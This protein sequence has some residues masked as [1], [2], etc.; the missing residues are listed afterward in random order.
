VSP[1]SSNV[2]ALVMLGLRAHGNLPVNSEQY[3][4]TARRCLILARQMTD[5][6]RRCLMLPRCGWGLPSGLKITTRSPN[7]NSKRSPRSNAIGTLRIGLR[8]AYEPG[9]S[10]L[11]QCHA[12]FVA[13]GL[14][15]IPPL[16]RRKACICFRCKPAQSTAC[17]KAHRILQLICCDCMVPS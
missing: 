4:R 10:P 14:R 5:L 15:P 2:Y 11:P 13:I 6:E 12:G 9:S 3:R 1:I 16:L 8:F 7:S 17:M